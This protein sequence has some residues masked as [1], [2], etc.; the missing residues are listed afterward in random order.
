MCADMWL[1]MMWSDMCFD[2]CSDMRVDLPFRIVAHRRHAPRK[3]S[4]FK[5]IHDPARADVGRAVAM[6]PTAVRIDTE[7][8]GSHLYSYGPI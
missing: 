5:K 7:V 6:G 8:P 2:L 4:L 1:D 3:S